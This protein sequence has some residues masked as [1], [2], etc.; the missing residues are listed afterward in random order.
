MPRGG[1]KPTVDTQVLV[2]LST[3]TLPDQATRTMA[4]TAD[5]NATTMRSIWRAQRVEATFD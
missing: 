4:I 3:Q 2:R 5:V 1:R